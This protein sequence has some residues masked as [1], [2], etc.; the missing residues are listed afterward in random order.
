[1]MLCIYYE[2]FVEKKATH[3]EIEIPERTGVTPIPIMTPKNVKETEAFSIPL[4]SKKEIDDIVNQTTA[5]II[6]KKSNKKHANDVITIYKCVSLF[7][8]ILPSFLTVCGLYREIQ[9]FKHKS[10]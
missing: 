10:K 5:M 2:P 6:G 1:M 3:L 4:F 7:V 8:Y 9:D